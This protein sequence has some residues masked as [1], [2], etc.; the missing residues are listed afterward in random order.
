MENRFDELSKSLAQGISR[1]Q[2]VKL[3]AAGLAGA[4]FAAL[5]GKAQADPQTCVTCVCG[6]G[7]PCNP[8]STTCAELREFPVG[9]T[10]QQACAKQNQTFCGGA[11]KFHCPHGC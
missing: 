3:F 11:T 10:C 1:R 7:N 6:V 8:K 9:T 2:A 4:L 5:T